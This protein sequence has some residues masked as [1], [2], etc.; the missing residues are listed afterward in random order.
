MRRRFFSAWIVICAAVSFVVLP[1]HSI[2]MTAQ[3]KGLSIA[4][5]MHRRDHGWGDQRVSMQ[6]ILRN[7][8]GQERASVRSACT[9]WKSMAMATRL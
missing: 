6:M 8:Q 7:S 9:R 4:E 2:A 5:E 3:E 1:V